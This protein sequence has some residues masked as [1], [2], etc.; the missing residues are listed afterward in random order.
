MLLYL[1]EMYNLVTDPPHMAK[2]KEVWRWA[3]TAPFVHQEMVV[4]QALISMP[5][6]TF[7]EWYRE[8]LFE[9]FTKEPNV[10]NHIT[11]LPTEL[12]RALYDKFPGEATVWGYTNAMRHGQRL[13]R[14]DLLMELGYRLSDEYGLNHVDHSDLWPQAIFYHTMETP[15]VHW[16]LSQPAFPNTV[17]P[18]YKA[19]SYEA[20]K[21]E[22]IRCTLTGTELACFDSLMSLAK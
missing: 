21:V 3:L 13:E 15:Y 1:S 11:H 12:L 17:T 5:T 18:G 19:R 9:S 8:G 22:S 4:E 14:L 7:V 10:R 2:C 16:C 6:E 20:G